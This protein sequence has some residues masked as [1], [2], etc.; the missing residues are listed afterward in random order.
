[1]ADASKPVRAVER[2]PRS[3][4]RCR[5]N[6]VSDWSTAVALGPIDGQNDFLGT[7]QFQLVV[8]LHSAESKPHKRG[9]VHE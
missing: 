2:S 9:S 7:M 1:M 3:T 6:V 4:C 5:S 8:Q